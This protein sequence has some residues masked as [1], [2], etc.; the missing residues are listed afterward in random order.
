MPRQHTP[1]TL[2]FA[3]GSNLAA[4]RI[5]LACGH[6]I[7][8]RSSPWHRN[9]RYACTAGAGC[10]CRVV[11]VAWACGE[12]HS[13]NPDVAPDPPPNPDPPPVAA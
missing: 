3:D 11:W 8:T 6:T 1:N 2:R 10:G 9:A 4:Y 13:E 5:T 12:A 7:R